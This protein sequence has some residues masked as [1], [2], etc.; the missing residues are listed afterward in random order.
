M[1]VVVNAGGGGNL[2]GEGSRVVVIDLSCT[3]HDMIENRKE[4]YR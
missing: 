4:D 3:K 1:G 2:V